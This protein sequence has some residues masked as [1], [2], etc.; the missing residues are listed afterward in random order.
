MTFEISSDV[1]PI[2]EEELH[3]F[4]HDGRTRCPG[5]GAM[6]VDVELAANADKLGVGTA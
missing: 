2:A 3:G 5:R 1:D 4:L 6:C